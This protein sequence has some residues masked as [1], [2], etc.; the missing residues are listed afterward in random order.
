MRNIFPHNFYTLTQASKINS[1]FKNWYNLMKQWTVEYEFIFN[2]YYSFLINIIFIP[3]F[4]VIIIII[5]IIVIF[6][7]NLNLKATQW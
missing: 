2:K 1:F 3:P 5:I 4:V 7:K 6:T